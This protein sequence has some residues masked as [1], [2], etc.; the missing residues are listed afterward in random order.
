MNK[1]LLLALILV[2][3]NMFANSQEKFEIH[4]GTSIPTGSFAD[5][6]YENYVFAG[7]G[8]ATTGLNAGVKYLH[9][10]S[11]MKGLSITLGID[12]LQNG[13]TQDFKDQFQATIDNSINNSDNHGMKIKV[14]YSNYINIPVLGGIHYKLPLNN[15]LALY[16]EAGLGVN[17]SSITDLVMS[18]YFVGS[19]QQGQPQTAKITFTPL[20]R[21]ATQIGGGILINNFSIGL[22]YNQLGSYDFR[23]NSVSGSGSSNEIS[24]EKELTISTYSLT[25]GFIF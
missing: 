12:L 6:I 18:S 22:H 2:G 14:K 9:Q 20:T 10:L 21:F 16:A 25:A 15:K 4:A 3:L 13:L 23:G 11:N 7:S 24:S 8:C 5:N 17:F 1:I 19:F